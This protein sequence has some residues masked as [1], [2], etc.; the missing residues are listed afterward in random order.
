MWFLWF[1]G[2]IVFFLAYTI[3]MSDRLCPT[4]GVELPTKFG[5]PWEVADGCPRCGW[6]R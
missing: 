2:A 6:R 3:Y 4:C 5:A 1:L